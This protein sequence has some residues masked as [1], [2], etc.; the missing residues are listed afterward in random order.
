MKRF[1][2]AMA[3]VSLMLL[4][5]S[6][7]GQTQKRSMQ[8]IQAR[9]HR[10]FAR[11]WEEVKKQYPLVAMAYLRREAFAYQVIDQVA[12]RADTS[13]AIQ[14]VQVDI[15]W[16]ARRLG[17]ALAQTCGRIVLP[18]DYSSCF[19]LQKTVDLETGESGY[20]VPTAGEAQDCLD[21]QRRLQ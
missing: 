6:L 5:L 14:A 16:G 10:E 21:G 12:A 8:R 1:Y 3:T 17:L 18:P 4:G 7:G 11:Q 13:Q 20:K 2:I 15:C 19:G 9:T